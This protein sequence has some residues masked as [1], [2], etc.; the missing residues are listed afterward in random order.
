MAFNYRLSDVHS[1]LGLSQLEKLSRFVARRRE[2]ARAYDSALSAPPLSG[3][4]A[5][6]RRHAGR[7]SAYHLYVAQV[8][9]RG[10]LEATAAERKKLFLH[11]AAQE[12]H[13]Q[14]HYVPL[15]W[16]PYYRARSGSDGGAER[17][18]VGAA[19]Y[20]AASLSLPM[21]PKM[22]DADVD[23]VI[24]ALRQWAE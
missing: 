18:Y 3:R 14:V 16:Q 10:S 15:P 4:L 23:R 19:R 6:L 7:E 22:T 9:D 12:I 1:A 24:A 2:I 17:E 21:F 13:C 11:L 8:A 20:Y 5:P